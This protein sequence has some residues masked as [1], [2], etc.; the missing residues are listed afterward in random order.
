[1]KNYVYIYYNQGI[2]DNV[3]PDAIKKEWMDWFGELGENLV[4]GGNQFASGAKAVSKDGVMD[5]K[6][7]PATG[8]SIVKASSYEEA[9]EWAKKCPVLNEPGGA[10]CVYE[11]LPM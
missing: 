9:V 7:M 3:A 10:V 2:R 11:T 5:V 8:Y 4:D 6:D 1:M